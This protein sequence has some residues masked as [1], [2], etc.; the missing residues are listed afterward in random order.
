MLLEEIS[1]KL[2]AGE[3]LDL[4]EI[5]A[6]AQADNLLALGALADERRR[7]LH[8][9][10]TTFVRVYE[11]EASSTASSQLEIPPGAGEVRIVGEVEH[12]DRALSATRNVV[13]VCAGLPVTGFA[14]DDLAGLCRWDRPALTDLLGKL[15]QAGL[16]LLA[17]ARAD[18]MRG[19]DWFEAAGA[20]GL[21]IGRITVGE[22]T[23][24]LGVDLVRRVVAWGPAL[25]PVHAFAPLPL[26]SGSQPTTGFEDIRQVALARVLVDNV[27]SIQVDWRKYGPKLAQVALSFGAN[28]IDRVSP[29]DTLDLGWRRAPLEELTRNVRACALVPVERN[30]R[31]ENLEANR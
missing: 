9:S 23:N 1:Q 31:F 5:D 30:G 15:K 14:L 24:D 6:V 20:V 28:D 4:G 3:R 29:L 16:S 21:G 10:Q 18:R 7:Q 17:E 13:S 8:G 19:P 12:G 25:E 11:I 27:D 26:T 2:A 22:A